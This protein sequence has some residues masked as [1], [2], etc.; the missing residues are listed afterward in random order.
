M[1]P[2]IFTEDIEGLQNVDQ[3]GKAPERRL[4]DY[5]SAAEI[6]RHLIT[7]DEPDRVDRINE[8][9]LLDGQ[10]PFIQEELEAAGQGWRQN[11]NWG[12]AASKSE[13]AIAPYHELENGV[14]IDLDESV[15][16]VKRAEWQAILADGWRH[17]HSNI[18]RNHEFQDHN[19]KRL[20]VN[21]GV[22][23]ADHEHPRDFRWRSGGLGEHF[24][25]R[26]MQAYEDAA[27]VHVRVREYRED[28]L[29]KWFK[30]PKAEGV[31]FNKE[32]IKRA[33]LAC[34]SGADNR[35][36][37]WDGLDNN[38]YGTTYSRR[39]SVRL[40]NIRVVEMTDNG[41]MVS[42]QIGMVDGDGEDYLYQSK[43]PQFSSRMSDCFTLYTAGIGNGEL[44]SIKGLARKVFATSQTENQFINQMFDFARI[45]MSPMFESDSANAAQLLATMTIGLF[46]LI[47][48]GLKLVSTSA[49]APNF[50][51]STLPLLGFC[52]Q[53]G[54][55][56]S[57]VYQQSMSPAS[58][59]QTREEV[60]QKTMQNAIVTSAAQTLY[61]AS[62]KRQY[63][64]ELRRL[65]NPRY[66]AGDP[67]FKEKEEFFS[68]CIDRGVPREV[69]L[70]MVMVRPNAAVGGGSAAVGQIL[71]EKA[72]AL[73]PNLDP[74]G[75]KTLDEMMMTRLLGSDTSKILIP[76]LGIQRTTDQQHFAME[77]NRWLE[78]GTAVPTLPDDDN[79]LHAKTHD[80]ALPDVD[81][82]FA[83]GG[84]QPPAMLAFLNAFIPH[85]QAHL[86]ALGASN[87][88]GG[89]VGQFKL[90]LNKAIQTQEHM[91]NAAQA[92]QN[93][94]AQHAQA[95]QQ[96]EAASPGVSGTGPEDPRIAAEIQKGQMQMSMKQQMNEQELAHR[97][98]LHQQSLTHIAQQ[99]AAK[100]AGRDAAGASKI[101]DT[102]VP[103]T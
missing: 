18:W 48:K 37:Y 9:A 34:N 1:T 95:Q 61:L 53:L 6:V 67:G 78:N 101:L 11:N 43:K 80:A 32:E 77:E 45:Y 88:P 49:T 39:A 22:G 21:F 66:T 86:A 72:M 19:L 68:W 7:E 74:V 71:L 64:S 42:E 52:A 4:A 60:V 75:Q 41:E 91:T 2:T 33:M 99:E 54:Q 3:E 23:L 82:K 20:F 93:R 35:N 89:D 12:G 27:N 28:E 8:Q 73:R 57:G 65:V 31:G 17:L 98:A 102:V 40:F 90:N 25:P 97:E 96:A 70:K 76:T 5:K 36:N 46:N 50:A 87:K 44:H 69:V 55:Q 81:N 56:A 38:I 92:E 63:N 29:W 62:K 79:L 94:L 14:T 103:T 10:G 84:M 83:Q 16:G 85:Q 26:P 51:Q 30:N 15:Q 13:Q 58:V 24:F 100:A 47:P 59:E